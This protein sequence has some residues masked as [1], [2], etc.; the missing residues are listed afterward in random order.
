LSAAVSQGQIFNI[1]SEAPELK[2]GSETSSGGM[3]VVLE[4]SLAYDTA[5]VPTF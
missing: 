5:V 2:G 1:E 3:K 4:A